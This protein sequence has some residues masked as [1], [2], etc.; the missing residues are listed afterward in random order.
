MPGP[1]SMH[2]LPRQEHP[3]QLPPICQRKSLQNRLQIPPRRP[4]RLRVHGQLGRVRTRRP[5]RLPH[6]LQR[7]TY[8]RNIVVLTTWNTGSTTLATRPT[9]SN[10]DYSHDATT[11]HIPDN[12]DRRLHLG[13]LEEVLQTSPVEHEPRR[14]APT[15]SLRRENMAP[16]QST[17]SG[18]R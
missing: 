13:M 10:T 15:T 1:P 2:V 12:D 7:T 6:G 11:S 5:Q 17:T 8:T 9:T 3:K 18:T 16:R 14:Q 4:A